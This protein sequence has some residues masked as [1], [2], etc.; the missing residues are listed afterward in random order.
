MFGIS[1]GSFGGS[2]VRKYAVVSD[3]PLTGVKPGTL[4]HVEENLQGDSALYLWSGTQLS[5][6]WYKVATVNLAPS[7]TQG[8]EEAYAL[9]TDGSPITI[10]LTAEDP[11]GLPISWSYQ[12]SDGTLDGVAVV[13]QDGGTFTLT[14]DEAAVTN[15]TAGAFSLTFVASDGVSLSAATSTFTLAFSVGPASPGSLTLESV[16]DPISTF[17]VEFEYII[18]GEPGVLFALNTTDATLGGVYALDVSDPTAIS[19]LGFYKPPGMALGI[20]VGAS[21]SNG[22]LAFSAAD[23][24]V[25]V[26][27]SNT[28]SMSEMFTKVGSDGIAGFSG[29][30]I[31]MTEN[32][33][34]YLTLDMTGAIIDTVTPFGFASNCRT[35]FQHPSNYE[36][37]LFAVYTTDT[38][39]G[40]RALLAEV[41]ATGA[42]TV[43]A[44]FPAEPT[45]SAL[46]AYHIGHFDGQ[47]LIFAVNATGEA[48][49]LFDVTDPTNPVYHPIPEVTAGATENGSGVLSPWYYNATILDG[50]AYLGLTR[51]AQQYRIFDVSAPESPVDLGLTSSADLPHDNT[52]RPMLAFDGGQMFAIADLDKTLRVL[53]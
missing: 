8:P 31:L 32:P 51:A 37:N 24:L 7:L 26:D 3:L 18:A 45:G 52:P 46:Q 43:T 17:G 47:K 36:G 53:K 6:G 30:F 12:V 19:L 11:E 38:G 15:Q 39:S 10:S 1:G 48:A 33:G 34:G 35:P 41:S 2:G 9:P 21:Y 44:P 42:I 13:A 40:R 16:L 27:V 5:G 4:A 50:F 28:A 14:A 22:R 49:R 23:R 25:C 29:D 20:S